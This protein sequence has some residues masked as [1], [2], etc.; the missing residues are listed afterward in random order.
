MTKIAI[1]GAG[2]AGMVCASAIFG[3]ACNSK[4]DVELTVISDPNIP[5]ISVGEAMSPQLF[6][7]LNRFLGIINTQRS[8]QNLEDMDMFPRIGV[9]H[10]WEDNVHPHYDINYSSMAN[11]F[12]SA[13][14]GAFVRSSLRQQ[15]PNFKE[16]SDTILDITQD[17]NAAY[18]HSSN[19]VEQ[20]DY[21]F[22]CRGFPTQSDFDSGEYEYPPFETVNSLLVFQHQKEYSHQYTDILIHK[23]G[24]QFGINTSKRK[25]FGYL[26][27]SSLTSKDEAIKHYLSLNKDV[28][29]DESQVKSISWKFYSAKKAVDGRIFKMGNKLYFYEPIQGIPLHYYATLTLIMMDMVMDR[30]SEWTWD[31]RESLQQYLDPNREYTPEEAVNAFHDINMKIY[32]EIVCSNYIGNQMDSEFWQTTKRQSLDVL[33]KSNEF[34]S[35][36]ERVLAY[37]AGNLEEYPNFYLHPG[38]MIRQ[39]MEGLQVNFQ[40]IVDGDCESLLNT[41]P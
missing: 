20:F 21:V 22:D 16:V 6:T 23:N 15:W 36:S 25:A 37:Q 28:P 10:R 35:F 13:K 2:S 33:S 29:I 8:V 34:M 1:V 3:F 11:H 14:F 4:L 19:G 5:P 9:R 26:Y 12:D 39:Y 41:I 31:Y 27:N 30:Q 40:K 7:T 17:D 24:W 32:F 38:R 18:T